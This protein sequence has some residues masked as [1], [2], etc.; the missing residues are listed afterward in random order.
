MEKYAFKQDETVLLYIC[1]YIHMFTIREWLAMCVCLETK[2]NRYLTF[3]NF[4]EKNGAKTVVWRARL[5]PDP[6]LLVG[7]YIHGLVSKEGNPTSHGS[8][9]SG[10]KMAIHQ[11][12][13]VRRSHIRYT[14]RKSCNQHW[15]EKILISQNG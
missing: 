14:P 8:S 3:H 10:A 6:A 7:I 5:R 12:I 9:P 1:I 4:Q 11:H 15:R 13:L 2:M